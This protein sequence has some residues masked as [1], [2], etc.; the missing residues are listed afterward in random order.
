[1]F[2]LLCWSGA[3]RGKKLLLAAFSPL[4]LPARPCGAGRCGALRRS[5]HGRGPALLPV[6]LP[7][8]RARLAVL[9]RT[10]RLS[11]KSGSGEFPT[12]FGDQMYLEEREKKKKK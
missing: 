10:A 3:R 6:L 1:M 2:D 4:I 9:S 12:E 7:A 5:A 8:E 11:W